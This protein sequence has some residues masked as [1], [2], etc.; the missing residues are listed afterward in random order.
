LKIEGSFCFLGA[1]QLERGYQ[2]KSLFSF[3]FSQLKVESRIKIGLF[4]ASMNMRI[5]W[6]ILV[7][8]L[9]G[10]ALYGT[11]PSLAALKPLIESLADKAQQHQK[12]RSSPIPLI[13]IGGSPGVGKTSLAR[14]LAKELQEQGVRCQVIGLDDFNRSVEERKKIGT[15]W[16]LRHLKSGELHIFLSL[17]SLGKK[18]LKKPT[19]NQ[20]TGE[21]G[22]ES[23]DLS[24]IDLI[25]F[26]GIYALCSKPPLHFFSYCSDGIFIQTN[27]CNVHQWKWERELKKKRPRTKE[28]FAKHIKAMMDEY[29]Q[30]IEC[31]AANASFII[32]KDSSHVYEL[33][34]K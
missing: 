2:K 32:K 1:F 12:N 7:F 16:D 15:E 4:E 29:R 5:D 27:A 20:F 33:L 8:W 31:S 3:K 9:M 21:M 23:I 26:E 11:D 19:Y 10:S 25:L 22:S 6:L 28:E 17:V 14:T 13:G 34:C 30:N 18:H 24:H